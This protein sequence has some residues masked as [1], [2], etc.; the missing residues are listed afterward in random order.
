VAGLTATF[1]VSL[2]CPLLSSPDSKAVL[3]QLATFEPHE[4]DAAVAGPHDHS[5]GQL[6]PHPTLT[7]NQIAS[8][9][10]TQPSQMSFATSS[11]VLRNFDF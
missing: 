11:N 9:T 7:A 4:L 6:D 3:G 2:H 5:N 8:W 1:N 10:R